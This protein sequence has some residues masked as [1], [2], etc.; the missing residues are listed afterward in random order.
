MEIYLSCQTR[1][2]DFLKNTSQYGSND[3]LLSFILFLGYSLSPLS[4]NKI[5]FWPFGLYCPL[6]RRT[7]F[8][9]A[10]VTLSF[11]HLKSL[12]V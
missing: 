2:A 1:N 11:I 4:R 7:W 3:L 9:I 10:I 12:L 5:L 6:Q 8:T